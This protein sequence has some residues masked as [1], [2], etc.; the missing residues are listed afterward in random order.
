MLLSSG[1]PTFVHKRFVKAEQRSV[2]TDGS[3]YLARTWR[4]H[5]FAGLIKDTN[6]SLGPLNE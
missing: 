2:L 6:L 5:K 4:F 1:S 3:L